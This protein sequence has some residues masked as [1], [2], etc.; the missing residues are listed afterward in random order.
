[1]QDTTPRANMPLSGP[2]DFDGRRPG[3]AC[4][5]SQGRQVLFV[6]VARFKWGPPVP[7]GAQNGTPPHHIRT[8]IVRLIL[9]LFEWINAHKPGQRFQEVQTGVARNVAYVSTG[10]GL[11]FW[12]GT[13]GQGSCSSGVFVVGFHAVGMEPPAQFQAHSKGRVCTAIA[14]WILHCRPLV[15]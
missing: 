5:S 3:R 1:M 7:Y 14:R 9:S 6:R 2:F 11:C 8:I 13:I 12:C 4:S 15:D 10:S